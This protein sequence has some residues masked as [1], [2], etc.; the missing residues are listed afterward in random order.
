[1]NAGIPPEEPV[2]S[3]LDETADGGDFG[4]APS[5]VVEMAEGCVRFVHAA[6]GVHLDFGAETLSVLDHYVA[7]RRKDLLAKPETIGLMAQAL[8]AYFGEVV[9]RR[10]RSFWH[11][12]SDDPSQWELRLEP[13]YVSFNP[14][15]VAYDA[16]TYGDDE[17]PTAY[18][19]L[20]DEDREAIEK[21]LFDL[22]SAS[23]EEFFS[24]ATRLEVLEISVDAIKARM[25]S[26]GLGEVAF[27]NEDYEEG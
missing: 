8:G 4:R 13:V 17:G 7:T 20:E 18:F 24:F 15:A 2:G 26:S 12:E 1:M 22:P 14:V 21:R 3:A 6:L 23:D 16:I 27:G 25:M 10:V 19:E 5:R 9:R 11:A